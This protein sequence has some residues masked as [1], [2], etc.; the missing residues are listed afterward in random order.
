MLTDKDINDIF[1]SKINY[2]TNCNIPKDEE[3]FIRQCD[4]IKVNYLTAIDRTEAKY[5]ENI[6][7]DYHK[8]LLYAHSLLK[9]KN[10]KFE[11]SLRS[12]QKITHQYLSCKINFNYDLKEEIKVD[13][14]HNYERT[15]STIEEWALASSSYLNICN[16]CDENRFNHREL[17]IYFINKGFYCDKPLI[18]RANVV[19]SIDELKS[20]I[21][22]EYNSIKYFWDYLNKA[23]FYIQ[24]ENLHEIKTC[25]INISEKRYNFS[26]L[27]RE[28]LNSEGALSIPFLSCILGQ[29]I[30]YQFH[31]FLVSDKRI[32]QLITDDKKLILSEEHIIQK[33]IKKIEI[34]NETNVFIHFHGLHDP[35]L[36]VMDD[37][38][39]AVN[40]RKEISEL[41]EKRI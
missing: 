4:E 21:R 40:F 6:V 14:F 2:V 26:N 8:K 10:M 17:D 7:R 15:N 27:E 19:F 1:W 34:E 30:S 36:I 25:I 31:I 23:K 18:D 9:E 35:T 12:I 5:G 3:D 11:K 29:P 16:F 37:Y 28:K 33:D 22:E 13:F 41:R 38:K 24:E 32:V 39:S 20:Y